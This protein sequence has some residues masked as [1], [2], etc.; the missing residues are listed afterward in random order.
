MSG[1]RFVHNFR[2]ISTEEGEARTFQMYNPNGAVDMAFPPSAA[3][4]AEQR[5]T[6]KQLVRWDGNQPVLLVKAE[7][8]SW[9]AG[10]KKDAV[11]IVNKARKPV[12]SSIVIVVHMGEFKDK[13]LKLYPTACLQS[14]DIPDGVRLIEGGIRREKKR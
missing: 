14:F 6:P 12:D 3:Y 8:C 7:S 2:D 4:Y 13:R 5:V 10:I 1:S 11:L 9:H